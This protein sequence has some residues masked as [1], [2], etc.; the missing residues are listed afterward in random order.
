LLGQLD[1][2]YIREQEE[3]LRRE[4]QGRGLTDASPD[5]MR[6]LTR[7]AAALWVVVDFERIY[8]LVYGSQLQI[9]THLNS[10]P[11]A[12]EAELRPFYDAAVSQYPDVFRAYPF[13]PYI[14]YLVSQHLITQQGNTFTITVKGREFLTYLIR[15]GKFLQR[16]G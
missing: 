11:R 3:I 5:T 9:L 8:N 10:V 16:A 2:P 14:N 15:Q 7:S 1:T 6:V 13:E 12:S 4:L